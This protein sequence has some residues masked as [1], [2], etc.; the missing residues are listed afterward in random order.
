MKAPFVTTFLLFFIFSH[1]Q[2]DSAYPSIA[3]GLVKDILEKHFSI[4][5]IYVAN[6]LDS[7]SIAEIKRSIGNGRFIKTIRFEDNH[8]A[9]DSLILNAEEIAFIGHKL[10][11]QGKSWLSN[12]FENVVLVPQDTVDH[13]FYKVT[14][15]WKYLHNNYGYR[16]YTLSNPIFLR[17]N[18]LCLF[19][20][21]YVCD[22]LCGHGVLSFYKRESGKWKY[23][24]RLLTWDN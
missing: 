21:S 10:K 12:S 15:P 6:D 4:E 7:F 11:D 17:N 22:P 5:K 24:W 16:L 18:S 20:W 2:K 8:T 1:T 13:I 23:Y 3:N 19:Y 14:D 9:V